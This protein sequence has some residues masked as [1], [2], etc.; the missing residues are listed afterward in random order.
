MIHFMAYHGDA[1]VCGCI[2]YENENSSHPETQWSVQLSEQASFK[3]V[4]FSFL[5]ATAVVAQ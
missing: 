2:F 3:A 4:E 5:H 1:L